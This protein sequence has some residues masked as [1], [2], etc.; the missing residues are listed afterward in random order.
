MKTGSWSR[1]MNYDREKEQKSAEQKR[2]SR[3]PSLH[4]EPVVLIQDS[5]MRQ[6]QRD[7]FIGTSGKD[8]V[9]GS[10]HRVVSRD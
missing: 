4:G 3:E 9:P 8:T 2:N 10:V 6:G 7:A 1:R 5:T